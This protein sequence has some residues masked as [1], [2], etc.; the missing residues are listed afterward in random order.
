MEQQNEDENYEPHPPASKKQILIRVAIGLVVLILVIL[1][2][3][4]RSSVSEFL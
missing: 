4:F 2:I 3:V 1:V